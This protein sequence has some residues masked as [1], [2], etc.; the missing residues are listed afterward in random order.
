MRNPLENDLVLRLFRDRYNALPVARAEGCPLHMLGRPARV[1]RGDDGARTFYNE[2]VAQRHGAVPAP[3]RLL[4][5]GPGAVH[6]LDGAAHRERKQIFFDVIR[7][8]SV[9]TLAAAVDEA[10]VARRWRPEVTLFDELV[11]VYGTCVIRWAG[12]DVPAAEASRISRELALIVDGF[13]VGGTA[14]PRAML[15]RI[16]TQRWAMQCIRE[17]RNGGYAAPGT[18]VRIIADSSLPLLVAATELINVLRPTVAVA[19]FGAEAA[20]QLVHSPQWRE[21]LARADAAAAR[22]F[23]LEL[24][25]WYPFAPLLA[26][27][28]RERMG[29]LPAGSFLVLDILGTNRDPRFWE[30]PDSFDPSRF[31]EREPGAFD[32]VPQGG[33]FAE[34]G[35]RCPGEPIAEALLE[36]TLVRLAQLDYDLGPDADEVRLDRIPSLPRDR[37]RLLMRQPVSA[38]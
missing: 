37:V 18:A 12:I 29:D 6:G 30:R 7:P 10:L 16:R 33:G 4:L 2:R 13:G 1:L 5:F 28:T 38:H 32:F 14:Y 24:R 34:Q 25:R 35:H 15:A 22:A 3:V 21:R 26:A 27:R 23:Q 31:L 20:V 17:V 36:T 8:E 11:D 9:A 19:Y